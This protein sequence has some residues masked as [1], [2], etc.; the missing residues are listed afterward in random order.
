MAVCWQF[1]DYFY[2]TFL[3][4]YISLLMDWLESLVN[5]PDLLPVDEGTATFITVDTLNC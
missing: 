1:Y 2:C 5:N 4:Q 3:V